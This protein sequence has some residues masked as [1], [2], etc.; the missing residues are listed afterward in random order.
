M[1]PRPGSTD[2]PQNTGI[3]LHFNAPMDRAT[4][5]ATTFTL[6]RVGGG[7]VSGTWHWGTN[8]D[9]LFRP[10]APLAP[11]E[12]EVTV[13]GDVLDIK[14]EV[15]GD[16]LAQPFSARFTVGS[17]TDTTAP[18]VV[19]RIPDGSPTGI[20]GPVVLRFSEPLEP[21]SV[22]EATLW[23]EDARGRWVEG[24]VALS[25]DGREA[26]FTPYRPFAP[27][28]TYTLHLKGSVRDLAGNPLGSDV[29]HTF[30]TAAN[31]APQYHGLIADRGAGYGPEKVAVSP[32][33][34]RVLVANASGDT[35]A[36]Y[37]GTTWDLL[38][39]YEN[40]GD[41]PHDVAFSPDG[42]LAFVLNLNSDDVRILRLSDGVT[43]ATI[44]GVGD[45]H[46]MALNA[47]GTRLYVT[48][49]GT[50]DRLHELDVDPS[51]STFG[52]VLRSLTLDHE[53]Y[54]VAL[55]PDGSLAYVSGRDGIAVIDLGLWVERRFIELRYRSLGE[56]ALA[57]DGRQA[58]AP[59]RWR[60][61]LH[62]VDL[63]TGQPL[64]EL[65][66]G[67][68]PESVAVSP[69]GRF[70][71]V[72]TRDERRIAVVDAATLQVVRRLPSGDRTAEGLAVSPDGRRIY[73]TEQGWPG[74]LRVFHLGD[75]SDNVAPQVVG[76]QP[77]NNATG[78][79]T[80]APLLIEL[81]EGV[82]RLTVNGDTVQLERNGVRIH[83]TLAVSADNRRIWFRPG[84]ALQPGTTYTLRVTTGVK[85]LAG[86][87]LA[88]AVTV[89]FT[90]APQP[91][92]P[93][94]GLWATPA[95][96]NNPHG[97][98]ITPDGSR[99]LVTDYWGDRLRI[100]NT[101]T[102]EATVLNLGH[103]V[104]QVAVSPD[105]TRA[106][107]ARPERNDVVVVDLTADGKTTAA[108]PKDG[109]Q[110]SAVGGRERGELPGEIGATTFV[111]IPVG[112]HPVSLLHHPTQP[113]LYVLNRDS[114]D[115]SVINTQTHQELARW[116]VNGIGPEDRDAHGIALSPD[117]TRLFVTSRQRLSVLDANDG[118]LLQVFDDLPG[119]SYYG[120]AIT[121]DGAQAWLA[122]ANA[123]A[124]VV[125]D[126]RVGEVV[127][128]VAVGNHPT[129]L[130]LSPDGEWVY[131]SNQESG[132]VS[133]MHR[134]TATVL[135]TLTYPGRI[136]GIAL[137]PDG[138]RLYV[139][140]EL[141][142]A[143]LVYQHADPADRTGPTVTRIEP[144]DA[145]QG[146]SVVTPLVVTFS[147]ALNRASVNGSTFRVTRATGGT[148][149][150]GDP[151]TAVEN[152]VIPQGEVSITGEYVIS[153]DNRTVTFLPDAPW[154]PGASYTLRLETGLTD[155]AGN[156]LSAPQTSSFRAA[157][158]LDPPPVTERSERYSS[159]G[160]VAL[161]LA[162]DGSL[163][164][165]ANHHWDTVS[166]LDPDTLQAVAEIPV[167]DGPF[168]LAFNTAGTRLYVV[169]EHEAKLAVVDVAA[170]QVVQVIA[171]LGSEPQHIVLSPDGAQA[172]VTGYESGG[173]DAVDLGT[174][175]VARLR[176]LSYPGQPRFAPDGPLY[177]P[178][179]DRLWRRNADGTW[180]E[181]YIGGGYIGDLAFSP[182]GRHA[183][184]SLSW[185][186]RIR[187][188][189]LWLGRPVFDLLVDNDPQA[190]RQ[191]S[192]GRLLMV[193]N[194]DAGTIQ[195]FDRLTHALL[196]TVVLP[197]GRPQALAW[198]EGRGRLY[199][200]DTNAGEVRS[201]N[202]P[203]GSTS[204]T[205]VADVSGDGRV[206][207]TDVQMVADHWRSE[208]PAFDVN[209]DGEVNV[210]D[211]MFVI[212]NMEE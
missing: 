134:R 176:T 42:T 27:G 56:I 79:P 198:D 196:Q 76:V 66:V 88:A 146:I 92:P 69:D 43:L 140:N 207:M 16:P 141:A 51:S 14:D 145:G 37:D 31:P 169:L 33:G 4:L 177:V 49:R 133:V 106:Y 132:S 72:T 157:A 164:A 165:V 156:P 21:G 144:A 94:I 151:P 125:I 44:A 148:A 203:Y 87:P 48:D 211:V 112:S 68:D 89:H 137:S 10:D 116:P 77:G 82:D 197:G 85:D 138:Q 109:G 185:G 41:G 50:P 204:G 23:V 38:R 34:A 59:D 13:G 19:E 167:G 181:L 98:A 175:Q 200:G 20:T 57:P 195:L 54:D 178:A 166:L 113:R 159:S 61:A 180:R 39:T 199:V 130:A 36:L 100:I 126:L 73:A 186:D 206:D 45:P 128:Q 104:G 129:W 107:V 18:Q 142:D 26:A 12:Y 179:R 136:S 189:D 171:G 5:D 209:G 194:E 114:G 81:S 168:G 67:E 60:D 97:V 29:T 35:V 135:N 47:G 158:T 91:D 80:Y 110:R 62:V 52:Q 75:L 9:V 202:L 172:Y 32:D 40:V 99:V 53:P 162:P 187:V 70:V 131:V 152:G 182:D 6:R 173:I 15:P 123:D 2:V 184:A 118:R 55:S 212:R 65:P 7:T 63:I 183:Y 170:R 188:V 71:Y 11:G 93:P 205:D 58:Y 115:V 102:W 120:V 90:T 83:G 210:L 201:F 28:A 155:L 108:S 160:P 1:L 153:A 139:P 122:S 96:G 46:L 174:G 147:E 101:V 143:L 117:G 17:G 78:I 8:R 86:N 22:T 24:R 208:D 121:P 154:Q 103:N 192:D 124:L 193:V 119:W 3:A 64:V 127:A 25:A 150:V 84:A 149:A 161:A 30:T 95:A 111:T 191:T 74:R 105:G 190:L 163:L